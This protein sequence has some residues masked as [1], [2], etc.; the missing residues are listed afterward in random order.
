MKYREEEVKRLVLACQALSEAPPAK[1]DPE[2]AMRLMVEL[3][4]LIRDIRQHDEATD[5]VFFQWLDANIP[6]MSSNKGRPDWV[7]SPKVKGQD[8]ALLKEF[9][10]TLAR[11][12]KLS[13]KKHR[14]SQNT[15]ADLADKYR[16]DEYT[17]KQRV[18][19]ARKR[20]KALKQSTQDILQ[21]AAEA[22]SKGGKGYKGRRER[23]LEAFRR[24]LEQSAPTAKLPPK[25]NKRSHLI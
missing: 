22:K 25:R 17:V 14:A 15:Y 4:A 23:L 21:I 1:F 18:M 3:D 24:I 10:D 19:R 11:N 2:K 6:E 12:V 8:E 20:R 7:K 13:G 9:E 16:A 5:R